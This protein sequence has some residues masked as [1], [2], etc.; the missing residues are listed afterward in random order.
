MELGD[1]V[2]WLITSRCNLDCQYCF[3]PRNAQPEDS[4]KLVEIAKLLAQSPLKKVTISGGEPLLI[5]NIEEIT[6]ILREGQKYVSLHTNGFYLSEDRIKNLGPHLGDIAI[7]V[8][9]MDASINDPLRG[10]GSLHVFK[11]VLNQLN[12][13][14]LNVGIHTVATPMNL[15][16]LNAIYNYLSRKD[17][18]FWKVYEQM[19]RTM[20][21][22]QGEF[23]PQT[24]GTDAFLADFLL[25]ESKMKRKDSR[26]RFIAAH[27]KMP[28]IFLNSEGRV[29]YG[30]WFAE[31]PMSFGNIL[32]GGIQGIIQG[33]KEYVENGRDSEKFF[34]GMWQ[35]PLWARCYNGEFEPKELEEVVPQYHK[36]FEKLVELYSARDNAIE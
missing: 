10:D 25:V 27:D 19:G 16:G 13:H 7:P 28:Y 30:P 12:K 29:S 35:L 8:D 4:R 33:V 31:K 11:R 26:I 23:D 18:S 21:R 14:E 5:E 32:D 3:A 6:K 20:E 22:L 24:G 2:N 17:F 1:K 9:S 15:S 36:R 34:E